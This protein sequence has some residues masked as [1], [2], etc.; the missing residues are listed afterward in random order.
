MSP[1][2]YRSTP[3][4]VILLVL[5]ALCAEANCRVETKTIQMT[6]LSR[7]P[8]S[9]F[10]FKTVGTKSTTASFSF[11][12]S[13]NSDVDILDLTLGVYRGKDYKKV[14]EDDNRSCLEKR[15]NG[16]MVHNVPINLRTAGSVMINIEFD[17][18]HLAKNEDTSLIYFVLFDCDELV[19]RR[20]NSDWKL[21]I[22]MDSPEQGSNNYLTKFDQ[23]V[24]IVKL[25]CLVL[26]FG[27]FGLYFRH[28][29]REFYNEYSDTNYAFLM[30]VFGIAFKLSALL[31]DIL[32]IVLVSNTGEDSPVINFFGK[33]TE[34]LSSYLVMLLIMFLAH[35]W[36]V[37]FRKIDEMELF[38]PMSIALGIL[39]LILV[40][41][42]R[43]V[44]QDQDHFHA[45]DGW[46]GFVLCLFN[47]G[48]LAYYFFL[49]WQHQGEYLKDKRRRRFF[50]LLSLIAV[51]Y[52]LTFPL[53]YYFSYVMDEWKRH[54]VIEIF[55]TI[56]QLISMFAMAWLLTARGKYSDIADFNFGLPSTAKHDE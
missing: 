7:S 40:G 20:T 32:E 16:W 54:S 31:I 21:T 4:L 28:I 8:F 10:L 29:K 41:L 5:G 13:I 50:N 22:T 15:E 39:K 51:V 19:R 46:V 11:K 26:I 14:Y 6:K 27:F 9:T 35:G 55:N 52:L 24:A 49:I 53:A 42:G 44:K 37:T 17:Y 56:G 38:L 36:T 1:K 25:I 33:A 34:L 45:F 12:P 2:D 43:L 47:F 3:L 18:R 23:G 48:M 30:I